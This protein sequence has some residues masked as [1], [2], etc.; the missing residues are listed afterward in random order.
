MKK[1]EVIKQQLEATKA[2]YE[3]LVKQEVF[4]NPQR[5]AENHDA[6]WHKFFNTYG[7][8]LY[9][10]EKALEFEYHK[11]LNR[12][13]EVGD[14]VTM[15]LYSDSQACTVIART[16]KTIT[17]QRDKAIRDPNFKPE[18]IPGGFSA[19]CTN[20]E[21]QE[22][23]YEPNPNG[24]VIKCRWSEKFGGWQTGSD[25]SIKIS[26]GRHEYYDYNF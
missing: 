11:E 3:R 17:I 19:I 24:E 26:R 12:E 4:E 10:K 23:T 16:A 15:H 25:G 5:T 9:D 6:L 22:W 13:I 7:L 1:S 2:E 20:S 21:D 14:G 18:W 8:P